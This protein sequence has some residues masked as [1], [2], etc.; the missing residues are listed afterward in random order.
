MP[1]YTVVKQREVQDRSVTAL[2]TC[3]VLDFK[4]C[5][6][7]MWVPNTQIMAW[8]TQGYKPF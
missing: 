8:L 1:L 6:L 7:G 3:C 2:P 4:F 5:I